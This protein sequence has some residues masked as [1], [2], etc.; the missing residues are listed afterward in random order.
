M[1]RGLRRGQTH[2]L[3]A[4]AQGPAAARA[5][6]RAHARGCEH[7]VVGAEYQFFHGLVE[8]GI[9]RRGHIGLA[10]L[11]LEDGLFGLADAV[12]HRGITLGV[13]E[14]AYAQIDLF[15]GR[16]GTEGGHQAKNRI[17]GDAVETLKHGCAS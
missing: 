15:R 3:R 17:I 12:Q 4:Q 7:R 1:H 9:A 8:G 6:D 11:A 14:H 16:I 5:L 2:Q 10:R 13:P